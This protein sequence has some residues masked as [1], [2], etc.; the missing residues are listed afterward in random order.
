MAALVQRGHSDRE[1]HAQREDDK[2]THR[3]DD[4]VKLEANTGVT[5]SQRMSETVKGQR[6]NP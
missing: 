3:E 2:E 1:R 4:N 6:I 5:K